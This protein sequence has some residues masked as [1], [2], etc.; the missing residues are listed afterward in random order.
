MYDILLIWYFIISNHYLKGCCKWNAHLALQDSFSF[1]PLHLQALRLPWQLTPPALPNPPV[2]I[3]MKLPTNILIRLFSFSL[4]FALGWLI[5]LI[6]CLFQIY[7]LTVH[8]IPLKFIGLSAVLGILLGF[9]ILY[10]FIYRWY[11]KFKG[12][13]QTFPLFGTTSW[14][15]YN[16]NLPYV[17]IF[18][19]AWI[20]VC[21]SRNCLLPRFPI[22]PYHFIYDRGIHD[23][24]FRLPAQ[25]KYGSWS[26]PAIGDG[27]A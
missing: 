4:R 9:D 24:I 13:P 10:Q 5:G 11:R 8:W 1:S 23:V 17:P 16:C 22:F 14:P 3:P 12:L 6:V 25:Q 21:A 15:P 20:A 26:C 7:L 19:S 18:A 27:S 2:F